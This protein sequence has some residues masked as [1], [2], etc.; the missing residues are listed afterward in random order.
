LN[1]NF[2]SKTTVVKGDAFKYAKTIKSKESFDII[3]LDPPFPFSLKDKQHLLS[4]CLDILND[5]NPDALLVFRYPKGETHNNAK[6][7]EV[8]SKNYGISS[9]SFYRKTLS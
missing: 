9:V 3:F 2:Y 7:I 8:F 1:T 5:N 6:G 4:L